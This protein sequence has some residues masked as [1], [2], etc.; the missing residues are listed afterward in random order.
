M[1]SSSPS[2][3]SL[4][5]IPRLFPSSRSLNHWFGSLELGS[6]VYRFSLFHSPSP[7]S[8]SSPSLRLFVSPELSSLLT[9][10]SLH[11]I[12]IK[13]LSFCH[14]LLDGLIE[15][16]DVIQRAQQIKGTNK[17]KNSKLP[18]AQFYRYLLSELSEFD[19]S[20]VSFHDDSMQ[21]I[22][23]TAFDNGGRSHVLTLRLPS[24]WPAA[25]V[26]I[27][28]DLPCELSSHNVSLS[29]IYHSFTRALSEFQCYFDQLQEFDREC[30]ILEPENQSKAITFRRLAIAR[31]C[32]ILV[33]LDPLKPLAIPEVKFLGNESTIQPLKRRWNNGQQGW[34]TDEKAK[35]VK[36][37]L[38]QL[39]QIQFP[40]KEITVDQRAEFSTECSICYSFQL[41]GDS[42]SISC[43]NPSCSKLFHRYCIQ[44]WFQSIPGT[45]ADANKGECPFCQKWIFIKSQ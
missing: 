35:S 41:N 8:A 31:G 36:K 34:A 9:S 39:L 27:S 18:N 5:P 33:Q 14:V 21:H 43:E 23:L 45:G 32:S 15:L 2:P 26:H 16:V 20:L 13:R 3:V 37:Q 11:S 38:E 4:P 10:S 28:A 19:S 44:E 24:L 7:S 22:S 42:P 12:L 25:P 40:Q 29:S 17:A 6:C 30:W 1:T